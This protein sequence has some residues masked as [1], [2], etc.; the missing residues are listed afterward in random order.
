MDLFAFVAWQSHLNEERNFQSFGRAMLLLFE[1]LTNDGWS[2]SMTD[3]MVDESSG[4]CSRAAGDCGSWL[5][6]PY[7]ISFQIL[8]SVVFLNVVVAVILEHF[9][10]LGH[11]ST[12]CER[13][14]PKHL[15]QS[16]KRHTPLPAF[17]QNPA[18]G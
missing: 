13:A 6:A 5:A 16:P 11:S 7:F 12:R 14:R 4:G 17:R 9:S 1:V 3:A 2:R 15:A 8:G 18:S 10:S